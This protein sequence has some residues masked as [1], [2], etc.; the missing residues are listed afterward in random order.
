MSEIYIR[1][2]EV[3]GLLLKELRFFLLKKKRM[4]ST[5]LGMFLLKC[6]SATNVWSRPFFVGFVEYFTG[7]FRRKIQWPFSIVALV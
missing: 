3:E 4:V 6:P 5:F 2:L 7:T 1:R